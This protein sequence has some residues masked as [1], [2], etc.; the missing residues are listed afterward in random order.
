MSLT[1]VTL[2]TSILSPINH[3]SKAEHSPSFQSHVVVKCSK[4]N[5]STECFQMVSLKVRCIRIY[6]VSRK[7]IYEAFGWVFTQ[8]LERYFTWTVPAIIVVKRTTVFTM[9]LQWTN[10][11]M[12]T[13]TNLIKL[14]GISYYP[15]SFKCLFL[16]NLKMTAIEC[17]NNQM[18]SCML[19]IIWFIHLH[20][21][22]CI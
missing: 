6:L 9:Y 11:K 21:L 7:T 18:Q 20:R 10:L 5:A 14:Y 16:T 13:N 1:Y 2:C 17:F 22:L 19:L 8:R 3:L 12:S 15:V 4:I